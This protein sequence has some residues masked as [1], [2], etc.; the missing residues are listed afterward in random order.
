MR[1]PTY[2]HILQDALRLPPEDQA[3]L[4]GVLEAAEAIPDGTSLPLQVL[5]LNQ[6]DPRVLHDPEAAVPEDDL[7]EQP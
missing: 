5:G 2:R 6:H 7:G 1:V 3:R 4:R